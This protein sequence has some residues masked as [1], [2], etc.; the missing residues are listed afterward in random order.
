MTTAMNA[1]IYPRRPQRS[2]GIMSGS[3]GYYLY[4]TFLRHDLATGARQ[5]IEPVALEGSRLRSGHA[6][7]RSLPG[8]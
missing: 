5:L 3:A 2:T 1:M 4:V 7:E 6:L 8:D